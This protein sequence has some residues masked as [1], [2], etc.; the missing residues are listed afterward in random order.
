MIA[1]AEARARILAGLR[2][3]RG[4]DGAAGR[5]LGPRR[6][7]AADGARD[8]A[9]AGRL[10][11]GR[12]CA[13]RRRRGGGREAARG[14]HVARR[15]SLGRHAATG[16]GAAA[17]H[18][19]RHAGGRGLRCCCRRTRTRGGG[20]RH[21]ARAR[22]RRPAHPPRRAGFCRGRRAGPGR[23]PPDRARCRAGGVGQPCPGSP[24]IAGRAW[25]SWRPATRSRCPASRSRP[26]AS[27]VP[28]PTRSPP[29]CAPA[30]PSR[31]CCRSRRTTRTRSPPRRLGAGRPAGHHRRGER[32]RARSGAAG[33]GA[34]RA[35]GRFLEDRDAARQAADVR[36]HGRQRRCS[37]CPATRSPR[38]SA[39]CCSCYPALARLG[40]LAEAALPTETAR[41]GAALPENDRR[42]DHLRAR[43]APGEDGVP[44]A[45]AFM[46]QDS[47]LLRLFAD[48]DALILRAPHAPAAA[49]GDAV[50]IIRLAALGI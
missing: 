8:A 15:A 3:D 10:G 11:D 50:E 29:W 17:V 19:Q 36:P 4:R 5:G 40:G 41:L 47:A 12:L 48:A 38:W 46:R 28:T 13:A 26:A 34:A 43:L 44:V 7:R 20:R 21:G 24:C 33:A 22:R 32:R 2:A 25:R 42:A 6:R 18:R 30:A 9:A 14:R 16:R 31:W 1:V 23:A 27:S 45:T 37:A 35:R 39:R 49:A